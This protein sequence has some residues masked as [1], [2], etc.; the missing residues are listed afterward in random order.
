MNKLPDLASFSA[1]VFDCDDTLLNNGEGQ[2]GFGL[3]EQSRLV[4]LSVVA[5]AYDI[6]ELT[7]LTPDQIKQSFKS[8]H[9]HTCEGAFWWLLEQ[10]GVIG[11]TVPFDPTHFLLKELNQA[12]GESYHNLLTTEATEVPGAYRFCATLFKNGGAGKMA[13]ASTAHR[14]DIEAFFGA[15]GFDEFFPPQNI[16]A[17]E[18]T[19]HRK[20]HSQAFDLALNSLNLS[21]KHGPK[22]MG[23]EDDPRGI[24]AAGSLGMYTCAV[25]TRYSKSALLSQPL[26]PNSVATD[27]NDYFEMFGLRDNPN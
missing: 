13:V 19:T 17:K 16:I 3:H 20:P 10:A 8:A 15:N 2:G 26:P 4:A 27:F 21:R 22:S 24:V 14:A 5:D 18:D 23:F 7:A 6:P 11:P 1:F 25:T 9:E 12:K